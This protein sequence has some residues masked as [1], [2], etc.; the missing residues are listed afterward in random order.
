MKS[1]LLD[2]HLKK[3]KVSILDFGCGEGANLLYFKNQKNFDCYGLDISKKSVEIAKKKGLNVNKINDETTVGS[4]FEKKRFDLIISIQVL[5]YLDKKSLE[6][7]LFELKKP[8]NKNGLV[9]FTMMGVKNKYFTDFSNRK[10]DKNDMTLVNLR[11]NKVY[12]KD[13]KRR[14]NQK[15][16][17]HFINFTKNE[18]DLVKKFKMFKKLNVGYYDGSLYSL[19]DSGF[20]YI[21]FGQN[22]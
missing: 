12:F 19:S 4:V 21:F 5:Y 22:T 1:K 16:Y 6:K 7:K 11:K 9:F 17:D 10:K 20:H 15:S 3:K 2:K 8:L 13:Y 18:R 14:Y